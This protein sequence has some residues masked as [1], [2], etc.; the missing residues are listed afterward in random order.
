MI[1]EIH[2][3]SGVLQGLVFGPFFFNIFIN[4][5][6]TDLKVVFLGSMLMIFRVLGEF[7]ITLIVTSYKTILV[8]LPS[9]LKIIL[10]LGIKL[11]V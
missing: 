9:G 5:D 4:D 7:L 1:K 6:V 11:K 3:F 8:V 2:V 10:H